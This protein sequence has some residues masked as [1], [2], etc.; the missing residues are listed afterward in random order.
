MSRKRA[1]RGPPPRALPDGAPLRLLFFGTPEF[2][3]PSLRALADGRHPVVG[4]VSQPDRPR[5]RGRTLEPTPIKALALERGLDLLQPGKV[6]S[7]QALAWLRAR[8]ADLG[9]VVAFGQFIPRKVR[10]SPPHGLINAHASLLP[11][12]R[13]A[14]PIEAA[15]LAG[16]TRT[17]VSIMKVEKQMD[18]GDV[19]LVREL[20]VGPNET[21]GELRP[22]LAAL[23]AEALLGAVDGIAAGE[24]RFVAQ[25]HTRAS[26]APKLDREF[27]RIDWS[28]PRDEVLRRICAATPRPGVDLQLRR[29]RKK[30]RILA[31]RPAEGPEA[32]PGRVDATSGRLRIAAL[33]GW[34]E[35]SRLQA[36]GKRPVDAAEYLRGARVSDDEEVETP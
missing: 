32:P 7:E 17:G 14:A 9:V 27:A 28:R 35:V 4:V 10:E 25:D 8:E 11:L 5:G 34:V 19:C 15:I 24:V 30:L 3:V 33:D 18:A 6:G 26:F 22:R 29:A 21:A 16:D 23:A 36:P 1:A 13:G 12:H 2:A 31:A 20:E